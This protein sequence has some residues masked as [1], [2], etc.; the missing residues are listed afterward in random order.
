MIARKGIDS[1]RSGVVCGVLLSIFNFLATLFLGLLDDDDGG[2]DCPPR[3]GDRRVEGDVV[4]ILYYLLLL[5]YSYGIELFG[6]SYLDKY[7]RGG[8]QSSTNR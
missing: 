4:A 7:S 2:G 8:H 6:V 5:I 3:R 1:S